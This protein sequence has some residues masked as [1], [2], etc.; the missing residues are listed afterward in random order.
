MKA[1]LRAFLCMIVCV[2]AAAST[3]AVSGCAEIN[4]S[5]TSSQPRRP[6]ANPSLTVDASKHFVP[7]RVNVIAVMPLE[8]DTASNLLP[9]SFSELNQS[10]VQ[11]V[12]RGTS[13]EITNV[14]RT[15]AMNN[16][17]KGV[18]GSA[19]S[20]RERACQVGKAVQAQ[21][22]LFGV[23]TKYEESS[24]SRFGADKLARAGFRLWLV[25]PAT[26][27]LLWTASYENEEQPL[28]DNLLRLRE[29]VRSGVGFRSAT[30]L[31][32]FGFDSAAKD[33][34]SRRES[35]AIKTE[36]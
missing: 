5:Q 6:A 1:I 17:V 7:L 36:Q 22:V 34:Q 23:V 4:S 2:T 13:L 12:Q 9:N 30:E 14:T 8:A 32:K 35:L 18:A 29:K 28:S 3:F 11:A 16:A 15:E 24:G 31:A 25:E 26:N 27:K 33:L 21:G 10:L 19:V 20:M